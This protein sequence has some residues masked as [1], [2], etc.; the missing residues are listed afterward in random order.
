MGV[1]Q[2]S[3]NGMLG[4]AAVA[5][6]ASRHIIQQEQAATDKALE[7]LGKEG[8]MTKALAKEQDEITAK[9]AEL[10]KREEELGNK[11]SQHQAAL[12]KLEQ[13]RK[14]DDINRSQLRQFYPGYDK[15]FTPYG[16][17]QRGNKLNAEGISLLEQRGAIMDEREMAQKAMQSLQM[18]AQA[19][20]DLMLRARKQAMKAGIKVDGGN[21]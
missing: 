4:T 17:L 3:I 19:K 20:Q 8:E 15:E 2:G 6:T 7:T 11:T 12:E 5:A 16:Y 13:D 9:N 10:D 1:I 21:I 14:V 18:R